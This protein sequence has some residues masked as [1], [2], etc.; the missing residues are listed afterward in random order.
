MRVQ[1]AEVFPPYFVPTLSAEHMTRSSAERYDIP[2][3]ITTKVTFSFYV[4][5]F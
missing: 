2:K 1:N 5:R 3:V 4:V